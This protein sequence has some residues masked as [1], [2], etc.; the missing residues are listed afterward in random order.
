[1]AT[2]NSYPNLWLMPNVY[3]VDSSGNLAPGCRAV[4]ALKMLHTLNE[5]FSNAISARE[6]LRQGPLTSRTVE[7]RPTS[8]LSQGQI[9][10]R[11]IAFARA[12]EKEQQLR[13]VELEYVKQ[14]GNK[15]YEAI[16][17]EMIDGVLP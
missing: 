16:V 1:K 10:E 13:R 8:G 11:R 14:H 7:T 6:R 5:L 17:R 2:W 9:R 12:Q 3:H 15:A 4:E